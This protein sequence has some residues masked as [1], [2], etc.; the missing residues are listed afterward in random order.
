MT[1]GYRD[2]LQSKTDPI[3][4]FNDVLFNDLKRGICDRLG[5][6]LRMSGCRFLTSS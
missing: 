6:A 5:I 2:D 4:A 1:N 3:D